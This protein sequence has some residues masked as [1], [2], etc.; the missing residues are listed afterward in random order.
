MWLACVR[1]NRTG[2]AGDILV[3]EL[4]GLLGSDL[5]VVSGLHLGRRDVP[6]VLV[7][8]TMVESVD[9]IGG[10][11]LDMINTPPRGPSLDQ[12]GLV[13]PEL[14]MGRKQVGRGAALS[15]CVLRH[16]LLSPVDRRAEHSSPRFQPADRSGVLLSPRDLRWRPEIDRGGP[17]LWPPRE[18]EAAEG[19]GPAG[20]VHRVVHLEWLI[21]AV[22]WEGGF[23][24]HAL[25]RVADVGHVETFA[26]STF[27]TRALENEGN[28]PLPRLDGV[29][30]SSTRAA[31]RSLT[32]AGYLLSIHNERDHP[33]ETLIGIPRNFGKKK[34]RLQHVDTEGT[35][36]GEDATFRYRSVSRVDIGNSYGRRLLGVAGH[37]PPE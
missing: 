32:E 30:L 24:G 27:I 1:L 5:S 6:A 3:R 37:P 31:L 34:F 21:L 23:D 2:V 20:R 22:Q 25:I 35:W 29:D 11:D 13:E 10:G 16:K 19:L 8:A 17:Q 33:D 12:L 4:G 14:E 28:S 15:P 18:G 26:S 7:E 36:E 9:P